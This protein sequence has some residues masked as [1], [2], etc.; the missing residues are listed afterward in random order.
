MKLHFRIFAILIACSIDCSA[1]KFSWGVS[2]EGGVN[3]L[4]IGQN[5]YVGNYSKKVYPK[6]SFQSGLFGNYQFSQHSSL[7][8]GL[9]VLFQQGKITQR[10]DSLWDDEL[11][12]H[13]IA[14]S[15]TFKAWYL[16]FPL[17]Y[18][19][20]IHR[21]SFF[22]G[23]QLRFLLHAQQFDQ[24][25]LRLA[26]T[27]FYFTNNPNSY[28]LSSANL[29]F[30][31]GMRVRILPQCYATLTSYYGPQCSTS[32]YMYNYLFYFNVLAG[33]SYQFAEKKQTSE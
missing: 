23:I 13:S 28:S 20:T 1:Q 27:T 16:T 21:F 12:G 18:S 32:G 5:Y 15:L 29:G 4:R 14:D 7:Y 11:Y 25:T 8:G 22:A 26:D 3:F 33:L 19:Y 30:S 2:A 10:A 31:L 9:N 6:L 24:A 17:Q